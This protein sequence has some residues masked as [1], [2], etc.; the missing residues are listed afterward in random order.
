MQLSSVRSSRPSRAASAFAPVEKRSKPATM[1]RLAGAANEVAGGRADAARS[2]A[3]VQARREQTE[4]T[5]ARVMKNTINGVALAC[6]GSGGR[7]KPD[8]L[9]GNRWESTCASMTDCERAGKRR[10]RRLMGD[11]ATSLGSPAATD[12]SLLQAARCGAPMTSE[13]QR[14]GLQVAGSEIWRGIPVLGEGPD[15]PAGC[16]LTSPPLP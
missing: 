2:S 12:Q 4:S 8:T 7:K 15:Q 13:D 14:T 5:S 1:G 10:G 11:A 9:A 16:C 3:A 6:G